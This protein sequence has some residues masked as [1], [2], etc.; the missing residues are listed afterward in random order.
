MCVDVCVR[1]RFPPSFHDLTLLLHLTC[2]L[3]FPIP[4]TITIPYYNKKKVLLCSSLAMMRVCDV[5]VTVC[6]KHCP[7]LPSHHPANKKP[8]QTR[9]PIPTPYN[10]RKKRK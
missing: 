2:L 8:T 6:N 10:D 9:H 5:C 3:A 4:K 1:F 7:S